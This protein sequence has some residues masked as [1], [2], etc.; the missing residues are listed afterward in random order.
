MKE[1]FLI[2]FKVIFLS[3]IGRDTDSHNHNA[4]FKIR[5]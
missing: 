4:C 1:K 3:F 2:S 5:Y